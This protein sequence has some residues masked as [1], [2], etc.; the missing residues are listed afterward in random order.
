MEIQLFHQNPPEVTRGIWLIG[1]YG[2]V[3]DFIFHFLAGTLIS[4]QIFRLI[5]F[6]PLMLLLLAIHMIF[7]IHT[8]V[9]LTNKFCFCL[10]LFR[11]IL[12]LFLWLVPSCL[13]VKTNNVFTKPLEI[14]ILYFFVFE[15]PFSCLENRNSNLRTP[16]FKA[17]WE[18]RAWAWQVQNPN[19]R[20][21]L[22]FF[23]VLIFLCFQKTI[24]S[25]DKHSEASIKLILDY[26]LWSKFRLFYFLSNSP[27]R[28][29]HFGPWKS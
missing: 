5:L 26:V 29:I 20:R 28:I 23:S 7:I 13:Y 19:N 24:Q 8:R 27:D 16:F 22:C 14:I 17:L 21:V 1:I 9:L 12:T 4:L 15:D 18:R 25:P 3:L 6:Q 10:L 11:L 2:I